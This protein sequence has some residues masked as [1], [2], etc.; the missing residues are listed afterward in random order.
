MLLELALGLVVV[1]GAPPGP[2]LAVQDTRE[3]RR[4]AMELTLSVPG[5]DPVKDTSGPPLWPDEAPVVTNTTGGQVYF[6]GAVDAAVASVELAF[7]NDQVVRVPTVAGEAYTG[8]DAGHARFFI[9]QV[10][11]RGIEDDPLSVVVAGEPRSIRMFDAAGAVVGVARSPDIER[12]AE[13]MRR[14]AGGA[15]VRFEAIATSRL[16]PLAFA[17]E[18]RTDRLCLTV[19]DRRGDAEPLVCRYRPEAVALG[20]YLGCGRR[21]ST[22][23]GFVPDGTRRLDVL[24]GSGRT[25]RVRPRPA[26]LGHPGLVVVAVLPRGEAT[27]G[28]TTRDAA[29]RVLRR[30]AVRA[31]PP[32]RRC[33]ELLSRWSYD[34]P[35]PRPRLGRPKGTQLAAALA[36]NGGPQLLARDD[37]ERLCVGIDRLDLD[38][39]DCFDPPLSAFSGDE[40]RVDPKQG[41]AFGVY[42]ARVAEV[43]VHFRGG[44]RIR[45]PALP[46]MEYTGRLRD[47]V[48]FALIPLPIGKRATIAGL[49][50]ASGREIGAASV[51]GPVG[52]RSAGPPRTVLREGPVRL[53]ARDDPCIGIAGRACDEYLPTKGAALT[54]RVLAPCHR[55]RTIVFGQVPWYAT[56]VEVRLAH[57]RSVRA[58]VARFPRGL[59]GAGKVYLA[60][61][62]PDA[63]VRRVVVDGPM[64]YEFSVPARPARRQCGWDWSDQA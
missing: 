29:G 62:G 54:T 2:T 48:H 37:G 35:L 56:R 45:A 55:R 15:T 5:A 58:Q 10:T 30:A 50:D 44:R 43:E 46:G 8:R 7:E 51:D 19:P 13:I 28:A 33:G 27:R 20:G 36:G 32:F 11:S 53:I 24:L 41:V 1:A 52:A 26:P 49:L 25:L 22:L 4:D 21:P 3:G 12:R 42:P 40:L 38:G 61:H 63:E 6:G 14:R 16:D 17:P 64:P 18:H 39:S 34:E 31:A 23:A 59:G 9:G 57:G 60:V 47:A